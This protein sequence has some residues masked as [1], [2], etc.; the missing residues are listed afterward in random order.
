MSAGE[1]M[2]LPLPLR[3]IKKARAKIALYEASLD[4]IGGASFRA[5][6]LEDICAKAEVSKVT[7]FKFFPQKEDV[8]VYFMYVWLLER[9][10][11]I[12]ERRLRGAGA[13][14]HVLGSVAEGARTRPGLM[15]SLIGFL[16]ESQ[17][18]PCMPA[19]SDAELHLLFPG[20]EDRARST[21]VDLFALFR[22]TIDEAKADGDCTR[23]E[24]SAVL[25]QWL[26]TVFYGGYLTAHMCRQDIMET[27]ELHLAMV[28]RAKE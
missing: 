15:L 23:G 18:H 3:E 17:M 7:F 6:K 14:R 10:L 9:L 8:L 16:S 1:R 20:R 25:G 22:R 2:P 26:T 19:L 28:F 11:E 12:E 5:V 27:Y 24:P 13:I 4:L 21:P